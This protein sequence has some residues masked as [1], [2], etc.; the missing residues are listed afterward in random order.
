MQCTKNYAPSAHCWTSG[1]LLGGWQRGKEAHV[2]MRYG[3]NTAECALSKGALVQS[4]M[5]RE[6]KGGRLGV[7]VLMA[8]HAKGRMGDQEDT[9][10]G[11]AKAVATERGAMG[12]QVFAEGRQQKLKATTT[13]LRTGPSSGPMES[14]EPAAQRMHCPNAP[15]AGGLARPPRWLG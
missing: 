12:E 14:W 11:L 7:A 10:R 9:R 3:P 2:E 6:H 1:Q 4:M 15:T 5:A 8:A 13:A